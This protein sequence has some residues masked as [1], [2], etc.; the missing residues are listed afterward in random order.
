MVDLAHGN[1]YPEFPEI[2]RPSA[3]EP[4]KKKKTMA[5]MWRKW[6]EDSQNDIEMAI[7]ADMCEESFQ[8][9]LF[10]KD[11]DDIELCKDIL[12]SWFDKIKIC[13]IEN[14]AASFLTTYPE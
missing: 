2:P 13:H 9:N 11:E 12:K 14:L 6:R 4:Q 3:A 7:L 5:N 1:F 10:M 8:P